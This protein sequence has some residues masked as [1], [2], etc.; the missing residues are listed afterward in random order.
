MDSFAARYTNNILEIAPME[1]TF[2]LGGDKGGETVTYFGA[3]CLPNDPTYTPLLNEV[4]VANI[5]GVFDESMHQ[6]GQE[7]TY[8]LVGKSSLRF[9]NIQ[10]LIFM[11]P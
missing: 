8:N 6:I 3:P 10:S 1:I 11:R 5:K 2:D 9:P 7:I 4:P